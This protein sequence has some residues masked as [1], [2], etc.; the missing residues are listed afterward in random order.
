MEFI[1]IC[2][3]IYNEDKNSLEEGFYVDKSA[4]YEVVCFVGTA[5]DIWCL[6]AGF[7]SFMN[8]YL[9]VNKPKPIESVSVETMLKAIAVSKG[10]VKDVEL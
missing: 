3:N 5:K 9:E 10:N 1:K 4:G 2:D 8:K 7:E 6:G